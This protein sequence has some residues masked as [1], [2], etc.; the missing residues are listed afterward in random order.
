[1]ARVYRPVHLVLIF[2]VGLAISGCATNAQTKSTTSGSPTAH[3]PR[4]PFALAQGADG[5]AVVTSDGLERI[6]QFSPPEFTTAGPSAV[7]L[8]GGD[9]AVVVLD[10][11]VALV[12]PGVAPI[13]HECLGC[14]GVAATKDGVVTSR[15]NYQPGEGFDLVFMGPDLSVLHTVPAARLE[16]RA[17]ATY[18]A[19]NTES[20]VTL[21]AD[22]AGVVVG[23]LSRNGGIRRGPSVV[24]RY[25]QDGRLLGHVM[26]DG[27]LGRSIASSDGRYLAIGVG[28]S[29]GACVTIS[30]PHIVDLHDL[31]PIEVAPELPAGFHP[32]SDYSWFMLTDL[33]WNDTQLVITGQAFDGNAGPSGCDPH[34]QGWRRVFDAASQRMIDEKPGDIGAARWFGPSCG[35]VVATTSKGQL[36]RASG[37]RLTPLGR[38]DSLALGADRPADCRK[39]A[40]R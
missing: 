27:V 7:L 18:P 4:A 37:S 24:A 12:G 38:Y 16:E 25:S 9:R 19:E 10:D 32:G 6:S 26:L 28:G 35:D 33:L 17:A 23:Y 22:A 34:P 13:V 2:A 31:T 8:P 36:L 11:H 1:M 40:G 5:V 30:E 39:D 20:P 29:G 15:K 21:A 3:P 14:V